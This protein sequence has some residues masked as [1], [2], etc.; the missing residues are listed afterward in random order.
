[1]K[2]SSFRLSE[3]DI[4]LL[5]QLA[6]ERGVSKTQ[7]I[8]DALLVLTN[9][10]TDSKPVNTPETPSETA[11]TA[12]SELALQLTK[13]DEQIAAKDEQIATL[14]KLLDQQQLLLSQQ[15]Q[16]SLADKQTQLAALDG[17][18]GSE[19]GNLTVTAPEVPTGFWGRLGWLLR[20]S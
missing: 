16:L 2:T 8:R 4:E 14:H 1:M 13:K 5:E 7:V 6:K 11:T 20:R 12:A 10:N 9:V 15:Q 18:S 17:H 3:S 19:T